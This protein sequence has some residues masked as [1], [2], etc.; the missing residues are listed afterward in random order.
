M[1]VSWNGLKDYLPCASIPNG[2]SPKRKTNLIKVICY[3][4][5]I[6]A[7]NEKYLEDTKMKEAVWILNKNSIKINSLPGNG[8]MGL[9]GKE[10]KPYV[11]EKLCI[12]VTK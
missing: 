8:N 1:N 2:T 10:I 3:G 9:S 12:K 7:L 6:G 4:R 5:M 11:K